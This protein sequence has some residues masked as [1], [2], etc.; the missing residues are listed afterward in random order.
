[1]TD[2]A[3]KRRSRKGLFIPFI[4]VGLV[5]AGWTVWWFYLAQQVEG[6]L[7]AQAAGLRDRGWTVAYTDLST[8]GWPFRARVEA[9]NLAITAPSG[10]AVAAPVLVA[11]ANAYEPTRWVI[12]APDGLTL[13]RADKGKVAVDGDAIRA[14]VSGLTQRYPNIAVE[15]ANARFT[16]HRDAEPFPISTASR[17]ELYV[18]PTEPVA[19]DTVVTDGEADDSLRVLFRLI[20]AEGRSGGPVE[21][22]AR[23]GRM[24]LQIEG[25]VEDASRLSGADT[26][27]IFAAW[28]EAG[29]RFTGVRG[30][31]SAGES[32][33]TLSSDVLSARPDGRLEGTV[34]LSA[35]RP[36]PAIAGLAGSGSSAVDRVGAAGATAAT[37][38]TERLRQDDQPVSL[39]LVFRNGR[40]FLGPFAL[41]PAPKLF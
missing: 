2:A 27:G 14:S 10:H 17:I 16:A 37:A 11:E 3:P 4:L 31:L 5:L 23:N 12:V 15:M 20:D 18:R 9:P 6:R 22:M 25:V 32:R 30:E 39:T 24:T 28:T 8:T 33:A 26:A 29:G 19:A 1:M 36:F 7:E 38:V 21:G 35:V 13:T 40:T 34:A 41:A